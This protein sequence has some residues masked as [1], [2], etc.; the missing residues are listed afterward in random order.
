LDFLSF[1]PLLGDGLGARAPIPPDGSA[2]ERALAALLAS[3]HFDGAQPKCAKF[4]ADPDARAA[5][6]PAVPKPELF[7]ALERAAA[8]HSGAFVACPDSVPAS[9]RESAIQYLP[10]LQQLLAWRTLELPGG[11]CIELDWPQRRALS[12]QQALGLQRLLTAH[13][14]DLLP[15][16]LAPANVA[17]ARVR[18]ALTGW[19]SPALAESAADAPSLPWCPRTPPAAE[20]LPVQLPET[21]APLLLRVRPHRCRA[22][23]RPLAG[24][25]VLLSPDLALTAAHVVLTPE[26]QVCDRYRVVPG[27]R[28]YT[29]PPAAPFGMAYVSRAH[30]SERAGWNAG[31][32]A[33]PLLDAQYAARTAHDFSWLVLD[34]PVRLPASLR[35]PRLRF[36]NAPTLPAGLRVLRAGYGASGPDGAV[37]PGAAVNLF[38]QSACARGPEPFRRFALWMSPGSSGGPVWRWPDRGE[39]FELAS[40]AVRMET[41]GDH[42]FETIGPHFDQRDYQRLLSV[43]AR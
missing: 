32:P 29:D 7:G 35:W 3:C 19:Q 17:A 12:P 22:G 40:L 38:G 11:R 23:S 20:L 24:S 41:H 16:R 2:L 18:A 30:L 33:A 25:G 26:G 6:P 8:G 4:D 36:G 27:G 9:S 31:A 28:R 14:Q 43:L 34:A 37:A 1:Y 10:E 21:I 5:E 42:Q 15:A 39:P 13:D